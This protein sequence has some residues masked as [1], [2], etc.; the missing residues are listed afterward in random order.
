MMRSKRCITLLF[1]SLLMCVVAVSCHKYNGFKRSSGFYYQYH[2]RTDSPE[3]PQT[4]D[5][6]VVNMSLRVG[7]EVLSPMTRY[8][9]LM[10][11]LYRGDI[12][13]ALRSMHLGDSATFIFDG[14]KFYEEFLAMGEYPYG[15]TPIYADV[16]LLKIMSKQSLDVAA[17][18]LEEQKQQIR[19]RE[20]SLVFE[21]AQRNH[22]DN[23]I[24]GVYCRYN[25]IGNGEKPVKG[26]TVKVLYRGWMLN[27]TEFDRNLNTDNPCSFEVGMG[28]VGRGWDIVVSQMSIGD[29]ITMVLPSSLAF[30]DQGNEI[31]HIPPYTPVVYEVE[32]LDIVPQP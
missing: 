4:G 24:A 8:N 3:Q 13:S 18:Q 32:L 5:F 30:G 22:I 12:Y 10:D 31:L 25:K 6:V 20:D 11:E 16:K 15:K 21:Y 29:N 27:G 1:L 9:M 2:L 14:R 17:E 19:E 7:D 26:Q 23:K 28:Q